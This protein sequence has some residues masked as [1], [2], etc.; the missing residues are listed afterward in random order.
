MVDP[1]GSPVPP[2]PQG[3]PGWQQVPGSSPYTNGTNNYSAGQYPPPPTAGY[4]P[5]PS[6]G[7]SDPTAGALSYI[8]LIPAIV[9]LV[10]PPYSQRPFVR[11]HAIQ[12]LLMW[13]VGFVASLA[14]V[15]PLLGWIFWAFV[16]LALL[17]LWILCLVNAALGKVFKV[18]LLGQIAAR[19]A[20]VP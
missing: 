7:L 4:I 6:Q 17:I 3:E 8:T 15:I 19:Y 16:M 13:A 9:F 2:S 10:L 20:N 18:P 12:H 5:A 11:F 1:Q 14:L